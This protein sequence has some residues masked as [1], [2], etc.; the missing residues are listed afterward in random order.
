MPVL[1]SEDIKR[2]LKI[3]FPT[4]LVAPSRGGANDKIQI[5]Y[6]A[7]LVG[8]AAHLLSR[9]TERHHD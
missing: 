5:P 7:S 1:D 8:F 2:L 9:L 6:I 3:V 4:F